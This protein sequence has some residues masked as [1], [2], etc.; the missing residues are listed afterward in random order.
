VWRYWTRNHVNQNAIPADVDDTACISYVL[1]REGAPV[2]EN[3]ELLLHCR[4]PRGLFYTWIAPRFPAPLNLAWWR[5]ALLPWTTPLRAA[6]FWTGEARRGDVDAVVNANVLLYLGDGAHVKDVVAFLTRVVERGEEVACD[7]YYQDRLVFHY[8][9]ARAHQAGVTSLGALR[10]ASIR[11]I[12]ELARPDGAIGETD[13][14]TGLA[15]CAL[16]AWRSHPPELGAAIRRLTMAQRP[17]GGWD[18]VALYYSG[19]QK[20]YCWGSDALSS[21]FCMEALARFLE[22]DPGAR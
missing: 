19:P 14:H 21:G 22:S 11:R 4:D 9:I 7:G 10:E 13:M 6:R 15:A 3:R 12:V 5:A 17:D 8:A 1:R 20:K 16:L 2:P 18:A